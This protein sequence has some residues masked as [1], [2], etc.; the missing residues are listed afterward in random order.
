LIIDYYIKITFAAKLKAG[1]ASVF[2]WDSQILEG[3]NAVFRK[4]R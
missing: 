4:W 2:R 3:V 1:V